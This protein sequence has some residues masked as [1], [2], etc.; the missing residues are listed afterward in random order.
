MWRCSPTSSGGYVVEGA[1]GGEDVRGANVSR[2]PLSMSRLRLGI[3]S[4]GR[5][6]AGPPG[7]GWRREVDEERDATFAVRERTTASG[8]WLPAHHRC[9]D[10]QSRARP[11]GR[12]DA[13]ATAPGAR[14]SPR[15]P[16]RSGCAPRPRV[17][18]GHLAAIWRARRRDPRDDQ[19]GD[20]IATK[21]AIG[22]TRTRAGGTPVGARAVRPRSARWR[23]MSGGACRLGGMPGRATAAAV[24]AT[25][26]DPAESSVPGAKER[27]YHHG[28]RSRRLRMS[29]C[30][31]QG[32]A[33]DRGRWPT[34]EGPGT[35][36]RYSGAPLA[37]PSTAIA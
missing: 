34:L 9:S 31:G 30:T 32:R 12:R 3:G 33:R 8:G 14:C 19:A 2:V 37:P 18:T 24:A 15:A 21:L 7:E 1:A 28:T 26:T 13:T 10:D 25:A 16:K 20:R 17:T 4:R 23:L 22:G 6:G 27:R 36:W 11:S 35:P 29:V 5:M